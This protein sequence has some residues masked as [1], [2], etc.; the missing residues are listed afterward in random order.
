MRSAVWVEPQT[1]G[2]SPLVVMVAI[3][4][5]SD[6]LESLSTWTQ[7]ELRTISLLDTRTIAERNFVGSRSTSVLKYGDVEGYRCKMTFS[8]VMIRKT[9][10]VTFAPGMVPVSPQPQPIK[11]LS[12]QSLKIRLTYSWDV[13]GTKQ[14]FVQKLFSSLG[15]LR[16]KRVC[17]NTVWTLCI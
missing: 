17:S 10:Q 14:M 11:G 13:V 3:R 4:S 7:K 16:W 1:I 12:T 6:L 8:T 5:W 15:S 9:F 2:N